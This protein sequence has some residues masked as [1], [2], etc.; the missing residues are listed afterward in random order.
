MK[1]TLLITAILLISLAGYSQ[2]VLKPGIGINLTDF[3][4]DG[5]GD[6]KAKVGWQI[7]AS[8]AFGKK[9]YF[10]PGIFYVE[11]STEYTSSAGGST[12]DFKASLSGIRVPLAVGIN[13]LGSEKS[14]VTLHAFGGASG[15]FITSTDEIN[16]DS[17]NTA[18]FGLFAGAGLDFWKLFL[19]LSYEWSL[20]N[21][22]KH[23][24]QIDIGK[25]RTFFI[26][27]GIRLNF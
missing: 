24:D 4:K 11:K 5:N 1:R 17:L 3:S 10:E 14:T 21:I 20:T 15:F 19:D 23:V 16:K 7:G 26:T 18:N 9:I 13:V 2:W 12:D 25:T 22:Q 8:A 27:A 6:A